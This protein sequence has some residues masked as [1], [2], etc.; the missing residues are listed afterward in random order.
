MAGWTCELELD[1][2]RET[3]AGSAAA[4]G[5]AIGRG[6]DLR[7]GT[8]FRFDEH[9]DTSSANAERVREIMDFRVVYLME[10]R[11]V[12][13]IQN[14]RMPV[15]FEQGF[16]PRASMSFFLYNQ[17][18]HQAI[19]RPFLDGQRAAGEPGPSAV[20]SH[21]DMPKY[22]QLDSWDADTNAP[23]SN[24]I[25]EFDSFRFLVCD[26]WQQ[27]YAHDA[28]GATTEGSLDALAAAAVEGREVKVAI[29]GFCDDL[30][31]AGEALAHEVFA[32]GGSCYYFTES[33]IFITAAQPLIRV[34]PGIP[35]RYES[36]GWDF[37]WI[38]PQSDGIVHRWLVDP[39]TLKF[40]RSRSRHAM[41]WFVGK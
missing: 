21:A 29:A 18:G 14:L 24:F 35:L 25:Y 19:A 11:W 15:S 9:I 20:K 5:A 33:R 38:K 2:A 10:E 40:H 16:G 31:A 12:A 41:R 23:S 22:R 4:L 28:D 8:V 13:G 27:V 17:D 1:E 32:H 6:A 34:R 37:G 26:Q 7:V 30:A 39:Y 3:V 36:R